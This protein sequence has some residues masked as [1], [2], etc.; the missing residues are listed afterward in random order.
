MQ[1]RK[2]SLWNSDNFFVKKARSS[3][4]INGSYLENADEI[5]DKRQ[6]AAIK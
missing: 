6:I 5:M 4:V 1:I 3:I 2:S